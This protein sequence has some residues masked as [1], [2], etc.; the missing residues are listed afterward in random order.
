MKHSQSVWIFL[1]IALS[2]CTAWANVDVRTGCTAHFASSAEAAEILG[3]EDEFIHR[4]SPFD[5]AARMKT[6]KA[7]SE[8]EF[9]KFVKANAA[10]WNE[11]EQKKLGRRLPLFGRLWNASR[12]LFRR[13]LCS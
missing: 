7:V 3:Q 5:R 10:S 11:V 4:L 12:L 13:E 2:A 6:D 1:T 9:L 8:A